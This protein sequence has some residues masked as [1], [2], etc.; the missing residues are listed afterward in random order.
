MDQLVGQYLA[1]FA[2][3]EHWCHLTIY[4]LRFDLFTVTTTNVPGQHNNVQRTFALNDEA[5]S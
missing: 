3:W 4:A 2:D 1:T 5:R